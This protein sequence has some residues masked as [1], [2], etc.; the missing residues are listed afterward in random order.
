M[1]LST[2]PAPAAGLVK[3]SQL[4]TSSGTFTLPSGYSATNPLFVAAM[5]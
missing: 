1:S 4:F 5:W 2:F 3:Y